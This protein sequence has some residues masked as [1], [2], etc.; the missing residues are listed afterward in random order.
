MTAIY[1]SLKR[2]F[3]GFVEGRFEGRC[4]SRIP[5]S[6][7]GTD[8]VPSTAASRFVGSRA[9]PSKVL[10]KSFSGEILCT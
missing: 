8:K 2:V 5:D 4:G 6:L 1:L 9:G 7:K 3:G 10:R